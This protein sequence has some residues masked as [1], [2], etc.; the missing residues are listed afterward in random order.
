[1]SI[2]QLNQTIQAIRDILANKRSPD[3]DIAKDFS[4]LFRSTNRRLSQVSVLLS[5]NEK[6][7][8]HSLS[9]QA[10][11]LPDLI[12]AFGFE[13]SAEW[14]AL[15][16]K[17]GWP[18]PGSF[19][20]RQVMLVME[21]Y[22]DGS[23][24]KTLLTD[25][26]R[27]K[28]LKGDRAG[29]VTTLRIALRKDPKDTWAQSELEKILCVE[30]QARL[31][32]MQKILHQ[33]DIRAL[34]RAYE[35]YESLGFPVLEGDLFNQIASECTKYRKIELEKELQNAPGK[36]EGW[37][38]AGD[39]G[40]ALDYSDDIRGRARELGIKIGVKG[41]LL[42]LIGWA[43]G[44]R[45]EENRKNEIK[46]TEAELKRVLSDYEASISYREKKS[47]LQIRNQ[48]GTLEQYRRRGEELKHDWSEDLEVR[49]YKIEQNLKKE[50][51][52]HLQKIRIGIGTVVITTLAAISIGGWFAYNK[53]KTENEIKQIVQAIQ[54]AK[55][56]KTVTELEKLLQSFEGKDESTSPLKEAHKAKI[57][58]EID[59]AKALAKSVEKEI[60]EFRLKLEN[61]KRDWDE[62]IKQIKHLDQKI[63]ECVVEYR[64]HLSDI[65][66][67]IEK[68]WLHLADE[69]KRTDSSNLNKAIS[70][71][72]TECE[73]IKPGDVTAV[74]RLKPLNDRLHF[75]VKENEALP[76]AVSPNKE[77]SE[78][79]KDLTDKVSK[80][81]QIASEIE[82]IRTECANASKEHSEKRYYQAL[83][84]LA[85][86]PEI[87]T[88]LLKV[89]KSAAK[90]SETSAKI[91]AK[92]WI[93]FNDA[94]E[95]ENSDGKGSLY[96]TAT[97]KEKEISRD[98]L[99]RAYLDT[100]C[101]YHIPDETVGTL[102]MSTVYSIGKIQD[103]YQDSRGRWYAKSCRIFNTDLK[104]FEIKKRLLLSTD[105]SEPIATDEP[106]SRLFRES[107]MK[108]FLEALADGSAKA[109]KIPVGR[110]ID[111]IAKST[112]VPESGRAFLLQR[113]AEICAIRP[114]VFGVSYLP[115][116]TS[117][118]EKL[119]AITVNEAEWIMSN[120]P[121]NPSWNISFVPKNNESQ[122]EFF[123]NLINLGMTSEL[124][125]IDFIPESGLFPEI[126]EVLG[127]YVIPLENG[128]IELLDKKKDGLPPY[129]PIYQLKNHP[130]D[131]INKAQ[132][133]SG[134][135]TAETKQ[136]IAANY[137]LLEKY[138]K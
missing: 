39:W 50:E 125:F 129:T 70:D 28:M 18:H 98:L 53:V 87:S 88:E 103:K 138:I 130:S 95:Y 94:L 100:I 108:A 15:C 38:K 96:E 14:A 30:T 6:M 58:S 37:K 134:L 118:L 79:L 23:R 78:N 32:Q 29:A 2:N 42:S 54:D 5:Q 72:K 64:P 33:G 124:T 45:E 91:R 93:P 25:E 61:P 9:E 102:K 85:L 107:G 77:T 65:K 136:I 73:S 115:W 34:N 24:S 114:Q 119:K 83:E 16:R 52:I 133:R 76:E 60:E 123:R 117:Y 128:K 131:I 122:M 132:E 71:C 49:R 137:P 86:Q 116:Y 8:A 99:D 80:K 120:S 7:Q 12:R 31:L 110:I 22:G 82:A 62:E 92:I 43:D 74:L 105:K 112:D 63:E 40:A 35:E 75:L 1:M 126:A 127:G 47:L 20:S 111:H 10:P 121:A 109:P 56:Q 113:L 66:A 57:Q 67:K 46:N 89:V 17:Q 48:L 36:L 51:T 59:R 21:S 27:G 104:D 106:V 3:P 101:I 26:F 11:A 13:K 84:K 135:S 69:K 19:D 55:N 81:L 41:N 97:P 44:C 90:L 4:E 68:Q